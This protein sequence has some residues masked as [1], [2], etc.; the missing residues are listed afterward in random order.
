MSRVIRPIAPVHAAWGCV[1]VTATRKPGSVSA[2][3]F[4]SSRRR[5]TRCYRAWSS[6][7]CSSDLTARPCVAARHLGSGL[8]LEPPGPLR[9]RAGRSEERRVGKECRSRWSP[10]QY[11]KQSRRLHIIEVML[12]APGT[13]SP[14][15]GLCCQVFFFFRA[16]DGIRDAAVTG[17]QTC[18]LPICG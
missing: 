4:F 16:E 8:A 11:K 2:M 12:N 10:Y 13:V 14:N 5:H 9:C 15:I 7:V 6:D 3:F 17:V 18:A 1:R